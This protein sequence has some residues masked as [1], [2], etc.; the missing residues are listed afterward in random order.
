MA[1]ISGMEAAKVDDVKPFELPTDD[2]AS[3][4]LARQ[5][6]ADKAKELYG[7]G[8]SALAFPVRD[9]E[10]DYAERQKLADEFQAD[11]DSELSG[12]NGDWSLV[13]NSQIQALAIKK[14]QDQRVGHLITAKR[15]QDENEKELRDIE[16]KGGFA[17][18]FGSDPFTQPLYNEKGGLRDLSDFSTQ[19]KLDHTKA[20]DELF[21]NM[22]SNLVEDIVW[23]YSGDII[24]SDA[25]RKSLWYDFWQKDWKSEKT[26]NPH[27]EGVIEGMIDHFIGSLEGYQ[28]YMQLRHGKIKNGMSV[29]EAEKFARD[30]CQNLIQVRGRLR[31]NNE[32]RRTSDR[33]YN[34]KPVAPTYAA[35][36][37]PSA[38]AA[39]AAKGTGGGGG[40]KPPKVDIMGQPIPYFKTSEGVQITEPTYFEHARNILSPDVSI[41][42]LPAQY[43]YADI[44]TVHGLGKAAVQVPN[45]FNNDPKSAA[46]NVEGSIY[47]LGKGKAGNATK[48]NGNN[49]S[50]ARIYNVLSPENRNLLKG[51]G[52]HLLPSYDDLI[53]VYSKDMDGNG[54][55]VLE[56]SDLLKVYVE[57]AKKEAAGMKFSSD[58]QKQD[59]V[60]KRAIQM[61]DEF[62][63]GS[64]KGES[65][66]MF[67]YTFNEKK[68][69]N[70]YDIKPE[71]FEIQNNINEEIKILESKSKKS[72]DEEKYLQILKLKSSNL[73]SKIA[74]AGELKLIANTPASELF[75][76]HPEFLNDPDKIG[77]IKKAEG[78][79]DHTKMLQHRANSMISMDWMIASS[80]GLTY[81]QWQASVDPINAN[82]AVVAQMGKMKTDYLGASG[83]AIAKV[84]GLE[85]TIGWGYQTRLDDLKTPTEKEFGNQVTGMMQS[86]LNGSFDANEFNIW[87]KDFENKKRVR[88]ASSKSVNMYEYSG[89]LLSHYLLEKLGYDYTKQ[90]FMTPAQSQVLEYLNEVQKQY[91]KEDAGTYSVNIAQAEDKKNKYNKQVSENII[92]KKDADPKVLAYFKAQDFAKTEKIVSSKVFTFQDGT[93]EG[94]N[95]WNTAR[96][97]GVSHLQASWDANNP[98]G[99]IKRMKYGGLDTD[100]KRVDVVEED[101]NKQGLIIKQAIAQYKKRFP[102]AD[103]IEISFPQ[104]IAELSKEQGGAFIGVNADIDNNTTIFNAIFRVDID[105]GTGT[106]LQVDIEV[107][108]PG[109]TTEQ[110]TT[111]GLDAYY[112]Q[113]NQ[114]ILNGMKASGNSSFPL[115]V[116]DSE[117]SMNPITRMHHVVHTDMNINAD[118]TG[119]VKVTPGSVLVFRNDDGRPLVEQ[120]RDKETNPNGTNVIVFPSAE[121]AMVDFENQYMRTDKSVLSALSEIDDMAPHILKIMSDPKTT[122]E[123]KQ[124]NLE[125]NY[126]KGLW[127]ALTDNGTNLAVNQNSINAMKAKYLVKNKK[128]YAE[129][130][131]ETFQK[132]T[133]KSG[134]EIGVS[135]TSP[136]DK[137]DW[138]IT[139]DGQEITYDQ[140]YKLDKED[141]AALLELP[142]F[143]NSASLKT[144][145]KDLRA[146]NFETDPTTNKRYMFE[147]KTT[148]ADY[149]M[150]DADPLKQYKS[151]EAAGGTVY[152]F[153]K[154][155]NFS[156]PEGASLFV[157]KTGVPPKLDNKVVTS[158][159]NVPNIPSIKKPLEI[160]SGLRSIEENIH[161]YINN[162]HGMTKSKHLQANAIDIST[163][164]TATSKTGY[165][166]QGYEFLYWLKTPQGQ[167]WLETNKMYAYHHDVGTGWHIHLEH[168]E[169]HTGN[170]LLD[171]Q[172]GVRKSFCDQ[173]GREF[174]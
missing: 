77:A 24:A 156:F 88:L 54:I 151:S 125:E 27:I 168:R 48:L 56:T 120:L 141:L 167:T 63:G 105:A 124:R 1:I 87:S 3:G 47:V 118:N 170:R 36:T 99:N 142:E 7:L 159:K 81:Q 29:L 102:K 103:Q 73:T 49:P 43:N 26:N 68:G 163:D 22:G 129:A 13:D 44:K 28:Y 135:R 148:L 128:G 90:N 11:V 173:A 171:E 161:A 97:I 58:K 132:I 79:R 174:R 55:P 166:G 38:P 64:T 42:G 89:S 25:V 71:I 152:N 80:C 111:M 139:M 100:G 20:A 119:N 133:T 117:G 147:G 66:G 72:P 108:I 60:D 134:S 160:S 61:A 121:A 5:T 169:S 164:R 17:L 32:I 154:N 93:P 96:N 126:G 30:E 162:A 95:R 45:N 18:K 114:Q 158:L 101:I 69:F 137:T 35:P 46:K 8:A 94:V 136:T 59:Y 41:D 86:V 85:S 53:A 33:N 145:A 40:D 109:I 31:A 12:V 91:I 143:K 84:Y 4:I 62:K 115:T 98:T 52:A 75:L 146:G 122:I 57:K 65:G 39:A 144:L 51:T 140:L 123:Q 50:C 92:L 16:T 37:N 2:M 155:D 9:R 127:N 130:N 14:A 34:T 76:T 172:A 131:K 19:A 116:P 149:N 106:P 165:D 78:E 138:K 104:M 82:K 67:N 150:P 107:E 23:S 83:A 112:V 153:V 21:D 10:E 74:E 6:K 113:F 157:A 15:H 110:L 70:T